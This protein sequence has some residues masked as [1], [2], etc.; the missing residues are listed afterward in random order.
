MDVLSLFEYV[1]EMKAIRITYQRLAYGRK[2]IETVREYCN[3]NNLKGF[4]IQ[5]EE[6]DAHAVA[7]YKAVV[8]PANTVQHFAYTSP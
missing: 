4:F 1:F 2:M 5:A 8:G 3:S 6:E 7:F